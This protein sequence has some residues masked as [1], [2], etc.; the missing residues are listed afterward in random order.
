MTAFRFFLIIVIFGGAGAA[1]AILGGTIEYRTADLESSVSKEVDSLWGPPELCQAA[2]YVGAPETDGS[3]TSRLGDPSQS[4]VKVQF[5]HENRYKG[6]LWFSTYTVRFSGAYT[7]QA[8]GKTGGSF[9]FRL[10][11]GAPFF[12]SLKVK[13]DD[14]D[15]KIERSTSDLAIALPADEKPHVVTV[16]YETRGR[17]R[18]MYGASAKERETT[19]LR[20]FT[21]TATMNFAEIDYPKGSVSPSAKAETTATGTTAVWK[22][23]DYRTRQGMGIEMPARMNAGPIAARMAFWAPVSLFFFF[24]ALFA[25]VVVKKVPLHPMH[26]LFVSA[27]FFA[28]HILMAYLVDKMDIHEAFWICAAVSVALVVS[29]MRLVVGGRLALLYVGGAQVVYLIGFS[30][31][32]FYTGWTGL[33]VVI[34]AIVTLFALM[35][36]TGRL[37]WNEVFKRPAPARLIAPSPAPS[38]PPAASSPPLP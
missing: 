14:A 20:N 15:Q 8:A 22:F 9:V 18:W 3:Y 23:E 7:V 24:A 26:Y 17:D 1:W 32:F 5:V 38:Q 27:G 34:I 2:P 16:E 36:A 12:E 29:Y 31:A 25:I 37:D 4:D 35:Q 10:P 21:L 19:H 6:L 28:F 30:Y 11:P 13:I 33:T